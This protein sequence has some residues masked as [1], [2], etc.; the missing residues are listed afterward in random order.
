MAEPVLLHQI[1]E[2]AATEHPHAPAVTGAGETRTYEQLGRATA[3]T[4]SWLRSLRTRRGERLLIQADLPH[5][6]ELI[7]ASSMLG[8]VA[9]P[10]HP[11]AK[12]SILR[13][14]MGDSEPSLVITSQHGW[15]DTAHSLGL[16][17]GTAPETSFRLLA[18]TPTDLSAATDPVLMIYTSGSTAMP[19][20]V[21]SSHAQALFAISAIQ[22]QLNYQ[23]T[24]VVF[25]AL[26]LSFDYGLYQLFLAANAGSHLRLASGVQRGPALA[27]GLRQCGATILPAV[28]SIVD[29]LIRQLRRGPAVESPRLLTT[30][31]AAVPADALRAVRE[32]LPQATVQVMYG[33]T[34]CKRASIMP[35]DGDLR[36]PGSSGLPLPGT[37]VFAIDTN[38]NGLP[39]HYEGE[40]VVQGPNVMSGYWRDPVATDRV[41][42]R[43]AGGIAQLRTGD[44]GYVDHEGYVYVHGR[45][46]SVYKVAG[47]RVGAAEVAHAARSI[48]GVQDAVVI[49][50]ND[51]AQY[52]M[53]VAVSQLEPSAILRALREEL[54]DYKIPDRCDVVEQLPVNTNG[55]VDLRALADALHTRAGAL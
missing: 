32:L 20:A 30:T 21:V 1:L 50:P 48:T 51:D 45:R 23:P 52:A 33:L 31:G 18:H 9:V 53:L 8:L 3:A 28:P 4:A 27:A 38:G 35:P 37:Q 15:A 39:P 17:V 16:P 22:H 26:P 25:G 46:D 6:P 42:R 11:Q 47:F 10:V 13:H 54:E 29:V 24:D 43:H 44:F 55:K 7:F 5:V 12:G 49:P 19:K 34:E 41:F 40:L 36:K 14:I 2:R